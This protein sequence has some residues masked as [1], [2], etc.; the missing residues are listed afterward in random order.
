MKKRKEVLIKSDVPKRYSQRVNF[1]GLIGIDPDTKELHA[2]VPYEAYDAGGNLLSRG[3][4]DPQGTTKHIF[5]D[6]P[7]KVTV[8]IGLGAAQWQKYVDADHGE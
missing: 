3:V 5:A 6:A 2:R 8:V 7:G 1:A 4:L